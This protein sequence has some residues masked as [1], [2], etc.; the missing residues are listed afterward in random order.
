MNVPLLD[1]RREYESLKPALDSAVLAVM[2][3]TRFINGPQVK[4]FEDAAAHYLGVKHA[5]GV[6][7]GTDALLL[8]LRAA[9][10]GPGTEVITTTFSFFA[11]AG[12]VANLGATP[13]FVDIDEDTFNLNAAQIEARIT[14]RTRAIIP[15]HL[16]G[17]SADLD[18]IIALARSRDIKV[19]EDAAQ[20][21]SSKYKGRMSGTIG[22]LGIYSF[23][24]TKNLGCPG[25]GGLIVTDSD[26][27]NQQLRSLKAHGAKVKYYHDIVGY[28]SRLDTLHAAVLQ[29]KLPHLD[30]WSRQRRANAGYYTQHFA[31]KKI[32]TPTEMNYG[33]HIFNQYSIMVDD[34]DGLRDHLKASG[35][36]YEIYY[37]LPLH[38]QKC[39]AHLGYR[40]GDLPVAER[41]AQSVISLPI[42]SQLTEAERAYVADKVIEYVS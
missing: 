24:P 29:V 20:S 17:Q 10:V 4:E 26:E 34:R 1:L 3:D 12:T 41:C 25:D 31:G 22:D 6:A 35:I 32:K 30:E 42:Y 16:F 33:Y 9:G 14:P 23:Y 36:G 21:L 27:L 8:A 19:V 13:V 40:P 37:P 28:N 15:V 7:S 11:T 2:A 18:P 39:F 5:I 38:L